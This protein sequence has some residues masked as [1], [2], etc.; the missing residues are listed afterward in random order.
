M[1][2]LFERFPEVTQPLQVSD[3]VIYIIKESELGVDPVELI[4]CIDFLKSEDYMKK[5]YGLTQLVNYLEEYLDHLK[6]QDSEID[7]KPLLARLTAGSTILCPMAI[8][9]KVIQSWTNSKK[10]GTK[11]KSI[12][13][14]TIT[15]VSPKLKKKKDTCTSSI[16]APGPMEPADVLECEDS[17]SSEDWAAKYCTAEPSTKATG[18]RGCDISLKREDLLYSWKSDKVIGD[19]YLDLKV[20]NIPPKQLK[21]LSEY[22]GNN[23]NLT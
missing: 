4:N 13:S 20:Y 15:K 23:L 3:V 18:L 10:P 14:S 5:C 11:R 2:E 16:I 17:T 22:R 1:E 12:A 21:K 8:W 19:G 7:V 6:S 9:K